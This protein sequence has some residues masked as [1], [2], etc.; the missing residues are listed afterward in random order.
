MV[1]SFLLVSLNMD[2]ILGEITL[3]RRKKKLD[4]MTKGEGLGDAYAATLS[5]MKAQQGSRSKLGMEVLMWVSHAERPLRVDELCQALGIE[6]GSTDLNIR[7]I[8]A[9][10]TLLSCSLG[11]VTVEKSSST[12]RLVHYTL[13]EYLSNNP[14]LF[15]NPHSILAEVCLTYLNFR[16]VKGLSPALRS[17]PLAANFV[18]YASCYWGT[19]ARRETTEGVK[20]LALKLLD[21]YDMHIS[22]K[23]LLLH[24][25]SE[26]GWPFDQ[27]DTP[28]GFTGLHGAAYFGCVKII[29]A[30]LE[31]NKWDVQA[32]DFNGDTAIAWAAKKGQEEVV[33]ILLECKGVNPDTANTKYGRTPFFRA[34]QY[35]HE[36]VVRMLLERND[37]TPDKA[38]VWNQTPL[39]WAAMGGHEGVVRMLLERK[40]VGPNTV[41]QWG[42]TPLSLATKNGHEGVMRMLLERG[43][44]NPSEADDW[45]QTLLLW[46]AKNVELRVVKM[47]QEWN[48]VDPDK[49]GDWS[50]T[51]LLWAARNGDERVVRMLLAQQDNHP[52]TAAHAAY[53]RPFFWAVENGHEQVVKMQQEWNN[54]NPAKAGDWSQALLLWAARNG[55]QRV[56]RMLLSQQKIDPN[57]ADTAYGRTPLFRAA[58]HG[59][60]EVV[61]LLLGWNNINPD[62]ADDWSQTPLLWAAMNGHEGVVR[63][64]LER[65][66]VSPNTVD[67]WGRTPLSLATKNGHEGIAKLLREQIYLIPG[68]AAELQSTELLPPQPSQLL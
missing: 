38:D 43:D 16:H 21:G 22:S 42:R 6:E 18:E 19:H 20:T 2:A 62:K 39:L 56:V 54:V 44:V 60:E 67:Q 61:R 8:P 29:V 11:L 13:Q 53:G 28:R 12:V 1:S 41:D 55:D 48:N 51:L 66:D 27:D 49:A 35:G 64:L 37:V 52:N 17:A 33:R 5:R 32:T 50:Q 10:E 63:M 34:A 26:Q 57:T 36:G 25:A 31:T 68:H 58:A 47:Q 30:L 59:H 46:A 65:K 7:D 3:Y 4:E 24:R 40:D 23:I 9:I 45:S 14:N 15:I